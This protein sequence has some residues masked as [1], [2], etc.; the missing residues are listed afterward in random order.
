[1]R[2]APAG[3][4]FYGT[5]AVSP[6]RKGSIM[7]TSLFLLFVLLRIIAPPALAQDTNLTAACVESYDPTVDYFPNKIEL[8]HAA[9][10]EVEYFNNY[11]V[12]RT[13]TPYPGATESVEYVLVQCG[14]P[15]PEGYEGAQRVEV[16]VDSFAALSTTQI[17]HLKE[18]GHL[19]ALVAMDTYGY[20][21]VNA[22][23]V[24]EM[25]ATGDVV[26]LGSG[27]TINIELALDLQPDVVMANGFDPST[28]AHPILIDAGIFTVLNSE[29][30]EATLL[31]RAEWIKFT[32]AFFN[33][34]ARAAE[35]FDHIASEY[36]AVSDLAAGV[37]DDERVTVL[38][39]SYSPYSE[40][41]IIPG[42]QTWVGQLLRD[43]GV[44]YVLMDEVPDQSQDYSFE[45]VIE[46][47]LD[48]PLWIPNAFQVNTLDDLLAQDER[49]AD[50]AAFQSGMV[51]NDTNRVNPNGGNDFWETG[52]TN[53]HLILQDLVS[54]F[55]PELLPDHEQVFYKKLG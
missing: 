42:Q 37:P 27:T 36:E 51:Y 43:A 2:P 52:V 24:V 20:Q 32:A 18:L 50:F 25:I 1:M 23:E 41:W 22:P 11:K 45:A 6:M 4:L 49:Y 21:L 14:T 3:V 44:N 39:N 47:G 26:D 55:Y 40:S 13:L 29:W 35:V 5:A 38:W 9:G 46:A 48:A 28:D 12:L 16:P 10:F 8:T 53:P 7:K 17:P 30:L 19:D 34:E 54:I 15:A 33:E 31:G